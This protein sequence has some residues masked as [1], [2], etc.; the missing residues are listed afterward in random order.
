M[1]GYFDLNVTLGYQS[2]EALKKV[3]DTTKLGNYL[4]FFLGAGGSF[5]AVFSTNA[6]EKAF[7]I[8]QTDFGQIA[9]A[10]QAVG[11][12]QCR[13]IKNIAIERIIQ[14]H[15]NERKFWERINDSCSTQ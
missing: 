11:K 3:N 13:V 2:R 5:D 9:K 6:V 12:I 14:T 4:K 10:I 7:T 8:T 15:S 1:D